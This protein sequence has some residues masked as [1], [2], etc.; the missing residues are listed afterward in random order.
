MFAAFSASREYWSVPALIDWMN[1]S[2]GA[3]E[4]RLLR[5][6]IETLRTS[7]SPMRTVS[8]SSEFTWKCRMPVLRAANRSA[9]R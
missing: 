4:I 1:F 8:S 3:R 2:L 5:H 6:I 7:A 9:M